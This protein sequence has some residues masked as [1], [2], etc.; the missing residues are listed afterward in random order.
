MQLFLPGLLW[1]ATTE[2]D[3]FTSIRLDK[4][5]NVVKT[6]VVRPAAAEEDDV[7]KALPAWMNKLCYDDYT[8]W[9]KWLPNVQKCLSGFNED[10]ARVLDLSQG[11]CP[12]RRGNEPK[13]ATKEEEEKRGWC[14]PDDPNHDQ[15][16]RYSGANHD[17]IINITSSNDSVPGLRGDYAKMRYG[18]PIY[19]Y[20]D[21]N[22]LKEANPPDNFINVNKMYHSSASGLTL[23]AGQCPLAQ[24]EFEL[25]HKPASVCDWFAFIMENNI[26]VLISLSPNPAEVKQQKAKARC[27]DY[28]GEMNEAT[29]DGMTISRTDEG[30]FKFQATDGG[31]TNVFK[32]SVQIT[33]ADQKTHAFTQLYFDSW[34]DAAHADSPPVPSQLAIAWIMEQAKA[35]GRNIAVHCAGGRGRTGT[36]ILGLMQQ[37]MLSGAA[38]GK[39]E[40]T[41]SLVKNLVHLRERRADIIEHPTQLMLLG[42]IF[43]LTSSVEE[44]S[45]LTP[46]GSS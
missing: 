2:E 41:Q 16:C 43:N 40:I 23:W 14:E 25:S 44:C 3:E 9:S 29:C 30:A 1:L 15:N 27:H 38:M 5:E 17:G 45:A 11:F 39:E 33:T 28:I 37:D 31:N 46:E 36:V 24:S 22:P 42:K 35:L 34:P 20:G 13:R 26:N 21:N 12:S 4:A 19:F 32:R 7:L 8:I 10:D 6:V 18:D